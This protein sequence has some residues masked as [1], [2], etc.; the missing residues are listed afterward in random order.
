MNVEKMTTA[1]T[2]KLT[3]D[4]NEVVTQKGKSVLVIEDLISTG[5]SSVGAV[6]GVRNAGGVVN[7]CL[8]IFTYGLEKSDQ[9]FS[10]AG[11]RLLCI[12]DFATLVNVAKENGYVS[13]EE[14][15]LSVLLLEAHP[16][17]H[18]WSR[19]RGCLLLHGA[20]PANLPA[21]LFSSLE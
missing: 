8:A 20:C 21:G 15:E 2:I 1:E 5:G 14:Y 10:Q 4:D 12:T 17:S 13:P 6:D 11:C 16:V 7:N 18:H 9:K 19:Q 3:I